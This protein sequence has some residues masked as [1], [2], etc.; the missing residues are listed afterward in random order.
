MS[1]QHQSS[2]K[3]TLGFWALLVY[4]VGDILGAGIYAVVGV[5]AAIAGYSTWISFAVAMAVALLTAL[6]YAELGGRCP[7]SGGASYFCQEAFRRRDIP[8]LIG[9]LVLCSGI[10]SM[11]AGSHAFAR[12]L[13]QIWPE[14]VHW[15]VWP[16]SLAFLIL[17]G[18][19]NFSGMQLS[20][21]ANF[22]CTSLELTGLM[23]VVGAAMAYFAGDAAANAPDIAEAV[24]VSWVA[25][26]QGAALAF[27]SFIGFED[28]VN[29]SEEVKNPRR[30][31]PLAITAAL[32]IAGTIYLIVVI[33]A[34]AVVT[35]AELAS[36]T[37][38]L[39]EVVRR[40]A[41]SLPGVLF[42][43][44]A[45]FA[46]SN[47]A[48]LN[49]IMGSRLLYGMSRQNLLPAWLG[50]VHRTRRTPVAA[51]LVVMFI[52]I[53]LA[54]AGDLRSLASTTGLMLF[55]VFTAVHIALIAIK[56][57]D[58]SG[59]TGFRVPMFVP[60]LGI[61][62]NI[63]MMP[64]AQ[65]ASMWQAAVILVIGLVILAVQWLRPAQPGTAI[66]PN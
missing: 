38:G 5:V 16:F 8:L 45:L 23:I 36:P 66:G 61:I 10:V 35:P 64:F 3:P 60:V 65:R 19:I 56:R 50:T 1:D 53:A 30:N 11:A 59:Y 52:S 58:K 40:G 18:T 26:L 48:L 15:P 20:S 57:R 42:S 37:G 6:S 25:I 9:W 7:R 24:N 43:V 22:V 46:I 33:V 28:L 27:Y 2:L 49:S 17:L 44:I 51:I 47:T 34:L 62:A 14:L 21:A 29:V 13:H 4:G 41:P 54:L 39:L 32:G 12:Y 63:G 55:A 31:V